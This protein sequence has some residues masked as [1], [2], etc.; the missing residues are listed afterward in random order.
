MFLRLFRLREPERAVLFVDDEPKRLLSPGL[1]LVAG[2]GR[3]RIERF[4]VRA[5]WLQHPRLE[6]LMKSGVLDEQVRFIQLNDQ[7]RAVVWL[8]GRFERTLEPGLH[9]LWTPFYTVDVDILSTLDPVLCH[10]KLDVLVEAGAFAEELE[11]LD[12]D[13]SQRA[14]LWVD[15]RF[16]AILGPGL[17]GLW[18]PFRRIRT[19]VV[20]V[21]DGRFSHDDLATIVSA[22]GSAVELEPVR[23]PADHTGLLFRDGRFLTELAPGLHALWSR[24]ARLEVEL[25][26]LREQLLDIS[27]QEL[28]TSDKVSLRLNALVAYRVTAP[29]RAAEA[30]DDVRQ[31]VYRQAQLALRAVVGARTLDD[32]LADRDEPARELEALLRPQAEELGLG[33]GSVGIRDLILPGEIR[34]LMNRVTEAKKAAE[35]NQVARR[36]ET[37]AMRSQANTARIVASNPT[38][39]KLRE[40]EVLEKVAGTSNLSVL[41]SET[42]L[43]DRVS[44]LI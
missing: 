6:V 13:D 18:T 17:H 20:E 39:L 4:S 24:P 43:S 37:A 42:G 35:A 1:H 30:T 22:G 16:T 21:G 9:A 15:G 44:K 31:A 29:R 23:V 7:Q 5:P 3:G 33:L 14:L 32:L 8:D 36:E 27:G 12:L 11:V 41:L 34:T 26:D 19:E 2:R 38:L 40:L 25:T 28:M 10:R